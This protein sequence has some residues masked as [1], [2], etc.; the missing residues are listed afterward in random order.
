MKFD[1]IR[2][3]LDR[4]HEAYAAMELV[5]AIEAGVGMYADN[6]PAHMAYSLPLSEVWRLRGMPDTEW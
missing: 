6:S 2:I 4:C 5:E 3:P 1:N